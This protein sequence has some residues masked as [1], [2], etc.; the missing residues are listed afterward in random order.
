[1]G[2]QLSPGVNVSEIDLTGFIPSVATTGGA[3][4][5][6]F[7]WGP[8]ETYQTVT[9]RKELE[10]IFGKPTDANYVDWFTASNFL[11]YSNNL[12]VVRVVEA[13]ALNSAS[14][15]TGYLIKNETDHSLALS[16][17]LVTDQFVARCPGAKGDSIRISICD[18]NAWAVTGLNEWPYKDLFDGAP[19]TSEWSV[20]LNGEGFNGND[21]LH[22]VVIDQDGLFTGVPGAVLETYAYLSKA[23]DAKRLD[24]EPSFYG[25]VLNKQSQY[26]WYLNPIATGFLTDGFVDSVTLDNA[27]SGYTTAP[28]V[29]AAAPTS[30]TTATFTATL[31]ATSG[32]V[33]AVAINNAGTNGTDG[34]ETLTLSDG[35]IITVTISGGAVQSVTIDTPATGSIT[36]GTVTIASSTGTLSDATFDTTVGYSIGTVSI[37][38]AGDGYTSAPAITVSGDGVDGAVSV[39]V[40]T[41]APDGVWGEKTATRSFKSLAT[42]YTMDFEGGDDGGLVEADEIIAGWDLF[43]NSEV[44]DVSLLILGDAGGDTNHTAVVKYVI[45]DIA[46]FRKDCV[47][48]FSPTKSDVVNIRENIAV[49]NVITRRNTSINSVS[50]YAFMDSGWKY[51]YDA[52][53]DKYRWLPLNADMAGL[54]VRTDNTADPW[55]SPAG[56]A[57]G[58]VKNVI[59]LALNPSKA[60]R[61]DLYKNCVN[62]VVSFAGEGVLLY[63][64]RTQQGKHSAFQK[65]NIR[66]LF[67]VLEKA[68][69]KAAKYMLFEFND[70]FTRAQFVNMVE[71]FLREVQGRRGIYDF[72]V[73]CDETNNTPEIIDRSEFVGDI[74]IKPAYSI[75]FIQ[76]NFVAVRTGVEFDEVIGAA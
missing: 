65:L 60:S 66:R 8:V 39:T 9:N 70:S 30:G 2:F 18:A 74:Y 57:R 41:S 75:N 76:L 4:V 62:P 12:T 31:D 52:Y 49:S 7:E 11:D 44:V 16:S 40:D 37:V 59:Q 45:D 6:Q 14:D 1:M 64:D 47:A 25:S 46:E 13:T 69:A 26:V 63:G 48:F 38:V 71:P 33:K 10:K 22:V 34:S 27:G 56:F 19:G 53:N 51:Q 42:A 73:V 67:I 50:S 68:I 17:Q 21:E 3:T 58:Q 23:S 32:V 5:G 20:S 55:Y 54:C 43:K 29:T 24:G 28:T 36:S 15:G 72:K 35:T 61:D